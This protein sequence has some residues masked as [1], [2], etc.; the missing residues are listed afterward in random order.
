MDRT[1]KKIKQMAA[2]AGLA[3][4][5]GNLLAA[6]G[7]DTAGLIGSAQPPVEAAVQPV[8]DAP[9]LLRRNGPV[10]DTSVADLQQLLAAELL[11]L[12]KNPSATESAVPGN[13]NS[14]FDLTVE[15]VDTTGVEDPPQVGN[16]L[17]WTEVLVGDYD[18]NG[19]VTVADLAPLGANLGANVS[20]DEAALHNGIAWWP[21]G[22]PE[23][24]GG[25]EDG[26]KP[27]ESSGA[28]NWRLARIDGDANGQVNVADLTPLGVH[29]G[30]KLD[31]YRIYRK[32]P[33]DADFVLLAN[34]EDTNLGYTIGRDQAAPRVLS[35]LDSARPARYAFFDEAPLDGEYEYYVAPYNAAAD[36]EGP[37]SI[38]GGANYGVVQASFTA[39]PSQGAAPLT[40][41]FDAAASTTERGA[42]SK[43]EWDF[44]NDG[45]ID[46]FYAALTTA[47]YTYEQVGTYV[48]VLH[49]TTD[50]GLTGIAGVVISVGKPPTAELTTPS[51]EIEIPATVRFNG[52]ASS[53]PDGDIK[54]YQWDLDN[55]GTFEV[56]T[57]PVPYFDVEAGETGELTVGLQVV[58]DLGA[59]DNTYLTVT[60]VDN[61]LEIENND[62]PSQATN[63]GEFSVGATLADFTGSLGGASYDGDDQDWFRFSAAE[64]SWLTVDLGFAQSDSDLNLA[65]YGPNGVTQLALAA[66]DTDNEHLSCGLRGAGTF[67][68][69]VSREVGGGQETADYVLGLELTAL[70]YD[71]SEDNDDYMLA[72]DLGQLSGS[73]MPGYW[74][75]LGPGGLDGDSEDWYRIEVPAALS[76]TVCLG[77]TH[78]DAD[79]D[80]DV[81]AADG[82]SLLGESRSVS[83]DESLTLDLAAGTYYV[84]CFRH[85][86]GSANYT[87]G[88]QLDQS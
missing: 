31:G 44:D 68:L 28:E 46:D 86:G 35:A 70:T 10:G 75:N 25:V 57:G 9:A 40:V 41:Q 53:D 67:Y 48:A 73:V 59:A 15:R 84:R 30:E 60:L 34:R 1:I 39:E 2:A 29:F 85:D 88:F 24:D 3:L 19:F 20:Y 32:G 37:W 23:E 78:F 42:I 6:C 66:S 22:N 33:A 36:A 7:G 71:E 14:V 13:G 65:L 21:A 4:V 76:L 16:R 56:D 47:S 82:D 43:Y 81:Y 58:D 72:T 62:K 63:L 27:A 26:G 45:L 51:S 83:N 87:L 49:V 17:I 61:Y 55:N 18:M 80:L 52:G 50:E 79:L 8:D 64:G 38:S 11:R 69:Q 77:F 74:G 12:G 54:N 5:V